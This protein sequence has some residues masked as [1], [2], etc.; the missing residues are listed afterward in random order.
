MRTRRPA[1]AA[2]SQIAFLKLASEAP[3]D[4][5]LGFH[6]AESFELRELGLLY[7]VQASSETLGEALGRVA[8]YSSVAHE[9]LAANACAETR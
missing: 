8:R 6:L 1:S 2:E 7:Y 5:L 3:G 9:G 4:P